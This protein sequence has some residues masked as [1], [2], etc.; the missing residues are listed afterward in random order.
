MRRGW[1]GLGLAVGFLTQGCG[2]LNVP[3][4]TSSSAKTSEPISIVEDSHFD[5]SESDVPFEGPPDAELPV[6]EIPSDSQESAHPHS[7]R[8]GDL[9]ASVGPALTAAND[10]ELTSQLSKSQAGQHIELT[11]SLYLMGRTLGAGKVV[12]NKN[13]KKMPVIKGSYNLSGKNSVIYGLDFTGAGVS[14]SGDGAKLLRSK[15]H[16]LGTRNLV[17]VGDGETVVI[18]YNEMY[19]WG[20]TSKCGASRGINI[21]APFLKG[22]EGATRIKVFRNYIHDQVGYNPETCEGDAEVIAAGQTGS[23][24]RGESKFEGHFHHNLIV[25]CMGDNEGFGVKSSYNLLEFNHLKEVRGFNLR[26]GGFNRFIGNRIEGSSKP[27]GDRGGYKNLSL[28][29]NFAGDVSIRG[30]DSYWGEN[31]SYKY[32]RSDQTRIIGLKAPR[33]TIGVDKYNV[34][35]LPAVNTLVEATSIEPQ[36]GPEQKDT[37][38]RWNK[39]ASEVVPDAVNLTTDDVGPLAGQIK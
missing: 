29:E 6:V 22:G 9:P 7:D 13:L 15:I 39:S 10:S 12:I 25:N 21:R 3:N 1:T 16:D 20:A 34:W 36:L 38:N 28:G 23:A 2:G 35:N 32:M 37:I 14:I 31:V 26:L 33:L 24:G 5:P 18:A 4:E 27:G 19:K 11:G 17:Y 8:S 30:G